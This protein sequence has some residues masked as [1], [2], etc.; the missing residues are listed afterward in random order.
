MIT[1]SHFGELLTRSSATQLMQAGHR[2][3][4]LINGLA[5]QTFTCDTNS[6]FCD[7]ARDRYWALAAL[8]VFNRVTHGLHS[9]GVHC[10]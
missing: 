3:A 2:G 1:G 4:V 9:C 10:R 5:R 7:S 6:R 8:C